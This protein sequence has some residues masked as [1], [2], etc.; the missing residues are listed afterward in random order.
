MV[1]MG[2][3]CPAE[4]RTST[5]QWT[6]QCGHSSPAGPLASIHTR[7]SSEKALSFERPTLI[8]HSFPRRQCNI[9][10]HMRNECSAG[11]LNEIHSQLYI[12]LLSTYIVFSKR[13]M[14]LANMLWTCPCLL[15]AIS[16]NDPS[17]RSQHPSI[18]TQKNCYIQIVCKD[19]IYLII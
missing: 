5:S 7:R 3:R 16:P 8:Q 14:D 1:W 2:Q 15:L 6:G 12:H 9:Y 13:S 19:L 17:A 10:L 4:L 18:Y 11:P